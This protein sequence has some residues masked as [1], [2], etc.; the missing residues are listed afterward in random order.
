MCDFLYFFPLLRVRFTSARV[1]FCIFLAARL[2][3]FVFLDIYFFV[4]SPTV[5][6]SINPSA[7]CTEESDKKYFQSR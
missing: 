4:G 6:F 3:A 7:L 5:S 2:N 1:F